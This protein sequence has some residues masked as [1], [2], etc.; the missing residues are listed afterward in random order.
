MLKSLS[1]NGKTNI[2]QHV[3]IKNNKYR[4]MKNV[5][6]SSAVIILSMVLLSCISSKNDSFHNSESS[7]VFIEGKNIALRDSLRHKDREYGRAM[8]N[9]LRH[10]NRALVKKQRRELRRNK[11]SERRYLN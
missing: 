1:P 3:T 4:H 6:I 11:R 10:Y 7:A 8:R 2:E 9:S 5:K